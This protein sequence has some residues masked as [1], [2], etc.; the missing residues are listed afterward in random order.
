MGWLLISFLAFV[1]FLVFDWYKKNFL[2][3]QVP[4]A[5]GILP[6][7]G[8]MFD[9]MKDP[10]HLYLWSTKA[11]K[12]YG[13]IF[14]SNVLGLEIVNVSGSANRTLAAA[15]RNRPDFAKELVHDVGNGMFSLDLGRRHTAL[16]KLMK[17]FLMSAKYQ[18]TINRVLTPH[19]E[20]LCEQLK[21][22]DGQIVDMGDLMKTYMF[23]AFSDLCFGAELDSTKDDSIYKAWQ[24]VSTIPVRLFHSILLFFF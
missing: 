20:R 5:K 13:E 15:S 21:K 6:I 12:E 9:C 7:F 22:S 24:N 8:N 4:R 10:E 11:H 3:A 16:K 14:K 17:P 23:D 2:G 19:L 1:A 18:D